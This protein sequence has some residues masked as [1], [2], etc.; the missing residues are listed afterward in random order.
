MR[1]RF[2]VAVAIALCALQIHGP[3]TA[4]TSDRAGTI[5]T[6]VKQSNKK[7]AKKTKV[8]MRKSSV[9]SSPPKEDAAA[10]AAIAAIAASMQLYKNALA[11]KISEADPAKVFAVQPQALLR[12]VVVVRFVID[13]NG[14][15][16]SSVIQRSNRDPV[17]EAA[18]LASL[19]SAAPLPKPPA[20]LLKNGRLE[21]LETWLFN[22]DGRFQVRSIAQVQKSE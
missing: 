11:R 21:L 2:V 16:V 3:A 1:S 6:P 20:R 5:A 15:L 10:I 13:R 14:K 9:K 7:P 12:S 19:R 22:D 18:A 8:A 4:M 17:T